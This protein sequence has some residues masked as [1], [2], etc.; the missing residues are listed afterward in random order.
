M[1]MTPRFAHYDGATF[2]LGNT[3]LLWNCIL[4]ESTY[5]YTVYMTC[6]VLLSFS[7]SFHFSP[8]SL[9]FWLCL[10]LFSAALQRTDH[11][12]G[13]SA[14]CPHCSADGGG[15]SWHSELLAWWRQHSVSCQAA[16]T[17]AAVSPDSVLKETGS[18]TDQDQGHPQIKRL[19]F[20]KCYKIK[21]QKLQQITSVLQRI[22]I[23]C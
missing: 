11:L 2:I 14:P 22:W 13:F 4:V 5:I 12:C 21:A 20:T 15:L 18:Q 8:E 1:Q 23:S 16:L 7:A 17:S 6:Y 3:L 9:C 19:R 10:L